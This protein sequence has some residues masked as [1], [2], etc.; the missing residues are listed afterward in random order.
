MTTSDSYRTY[1]GYL[2]FYVRQNILQGVTSVCTGWDEG[3]S[4][5]LKQ[6]SRL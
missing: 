3:Q 2:L 1:I 5:Q 6:R 4:R